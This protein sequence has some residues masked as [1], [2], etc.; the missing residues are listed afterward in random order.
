MDSWCST[1]ADASPCQPQLLEVSEAQL[2]PSSAS[3]AATAPSAG[4]RTSSALSRQRFARTCCP[5][6]RGAQRSTLPARNARK[7]SVR[8]GDVCSWASHRKPREAQLLGASLCRACWDSQLPV[9]SL[10][11]SASA[12]WERMHDQVPAIPVKLWTSRPDPLNETASLGGAPA[13][14]ERTGAE[15][16]FWWDSS[17]RFWTKPGES[18]THR[19]STMASSATS[20]LASNLSMPGSEVQR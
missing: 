14:R 9:F 16:R 15:A 17:R 10:R 20:P 11:T 12:A 1:T 4:K 6:S 7:R 18:Q 2:G 5:S 13:Y 3:V 19:R 8:V